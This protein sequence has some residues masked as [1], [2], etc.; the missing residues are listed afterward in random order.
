MYHGGQNSYSII[1]LIYLFRKPKNARSKRAL[2]AREPKEVE[3]A[4]IAVFVKGSH[5][6]EK[7]THAMKDL[8]RLLPLVTGQDILPIILIYADGS[9]ETRQYLILQEKCCPTIRGCLFPRLLV[10]KERRESFCRRSKHKETARR[11]GIRE[12]VR[13]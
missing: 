5:S 4:R 12:D 10:A 3:D 6:G 9:E 11:Y 13:L 2:E 8:V 1:F 7:V